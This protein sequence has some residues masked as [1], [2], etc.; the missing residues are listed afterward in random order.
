MFAD[1]SDSKTTKQKKKI[2]LSEHLL[3][4]KKKKNLTVTNGENYSAWK[5]LLQHTVS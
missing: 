4:K 2:W 1:K 5:Q 3:K